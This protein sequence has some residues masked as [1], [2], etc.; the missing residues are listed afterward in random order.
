MFSQFSPKFQIVQ[1]SHI[2]TYITKPSLVKL[3]P[4][5]RFNFDV[6]TGTCA[7]RDWNFCYRYLLKYITEI[8]FTDL[9]NFNCLRN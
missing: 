2:P 4:K 1:K 7:L 6:R 3:I 8:V 5:I 9:K